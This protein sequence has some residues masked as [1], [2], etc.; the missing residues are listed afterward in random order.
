MPAKGQRLTSHR[1][2]AIKP[3]GHLARRVPPP[4]PLAG[5][6]LLR[7]LEA[8]LEWLKIAGYSADTARTRRQAIRLFIAWRRERGLDDPRQFT[9]S[10]LERYQHHLFYRRKPDGR[11]LTIGMQG[12][13]LAALKLW[14]KWLA[15]SGQIPTNP[16]SELDLPRQPHRLPGRVLSVAE[17]QALLQAAE[18]TTAHGLRDRA[19][20]ELLYAT[21]LRR[22]EAACLELYDPDLVR[23]VLWVRHGKGAR[24][25][26]VPLGERATAWLDQYLQAA[27][28][29]LL[30]TETPAL[31]LTDY[32][33]P[34][35]PD[36]IA[37]KV[38]RYLTL[39]GLTVAGSTHLLRHACATHMLEGGADI[40]FIQALLGHACLNTTEIYTHVAIDQLI[41]VHR[42]TH[43]NR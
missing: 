25:R 40:R 39:A 1:I 8:H 43:P 11:P 24:Q 27:W 9:P 19:L 14:F 7:Y 13:Y 32:G 16:A 21:G 6:P 22:T 18:P 31:F 4:D 17:V 33:L 20:L 3:G 42:A 38:K 28:P 23:G 34:L 36:Q 37:A 15:R 5:Q 30:T 41:H 26:V 10:M 35:R 2:A 29:H 12:Q